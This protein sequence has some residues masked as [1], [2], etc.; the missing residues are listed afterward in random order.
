MCMKT[1]KV[2]APAPLPPAPPPPAPPAE[3]E[4][5]KSQK[6]RTSS[7]ANKTSKKLRKDLKNP[8]VKVAGGT[9]LSGL[10]INRIG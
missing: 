4:I 7:A 2:E 6:T 5:G 3:I 8:G 9:R 1:P 10:N